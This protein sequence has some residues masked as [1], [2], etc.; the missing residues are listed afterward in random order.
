MGAMV[1]LSPHPDDAVL[2][3]W[4][5]LTDPGDV[6]VV[7]VFGGTPE[8][9]APGWWDRLTRSTDPLERRRERHEEDR[10]ALALAGREPENLGFLDGQYRD[11]E[12]ALEPVVRRIADLAPPRSVLFAPASLDGHRSHRA[13]LAAGLRLARETDPRA[14]RELVLY[15][16]IPHALVYGWPGWVTGA[17]AEPFLDPDA[18]WE[19]QLRAAGLSPPQLEPHVHRLQAGAVRRK[20]KAIGEYRT[21]LPALEAQFGPFTADD[22]LAYE[23]VW[24]LRGPSGSA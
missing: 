13:V 19:H 3:L 6:R 22:V 15:A 23:V 9:A 8:G 2:S 1:I 18:H 24:S 4:H 12:Q 14:R 10:R 5:V 7:N 21:Q 11:G 20:R 16:D 17:A